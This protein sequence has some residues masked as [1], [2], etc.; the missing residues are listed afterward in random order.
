MRHEGR[1]LGRKL[2]GYRSVWRERRYARVAKR[3][4]FLAMLLPLLAM[5]YLFLVMRRPF[6]VTSCLR[7][8]MRCSFLVTSCPRLAKRCS[9]VVSVSSMWRA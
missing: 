5:H 6:V 3:C 7:L 4:L 1:G 8:A 9:F 2:V